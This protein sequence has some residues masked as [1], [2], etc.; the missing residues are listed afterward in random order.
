MTAE[1]TV[2]VSPTRDVIGYGMV[3]CGDLKV[4]SRSRGGGG[5]P[6]GRRHQVPL[7]MYYTAITPELPDMCSLR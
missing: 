1:G 2:L 3:L 6:M 4:L 7:C 5:A